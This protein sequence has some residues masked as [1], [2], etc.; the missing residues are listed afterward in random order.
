MPHVEG[1]GVIL[2]EICQRICWRG[3]KGV[4]MQAGG[5]D[6]V[7]LHGGQDKGLHF[8]IESVCVE[9]GD[10]RV[11]AAKLLE[12]KDFKKFLKF[13]TRFIY[14]IL[15]DKFF[16]PWK[17][18]QRTQQEKEIKKLFFQK[19]SRPVKESTTLM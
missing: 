15:K 3:A 2:L 13:E 1:S 8:I 5:A 11:V 6:E 12:R 4:D 7:L 19:R 14:I 9:N 18:L 17:I 16:I 10:G